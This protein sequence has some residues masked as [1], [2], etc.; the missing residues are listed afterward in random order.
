MT[1]RDT[2]GRDQPLSDTE[3]DGGTGA[4]KVPGTPE[5]TVTP[6][7]TATTE[8]TGTTVDTELTPAAERPA[9]EGQVLLVRRRRVPALGFWVTLALALSFVGGVVLA[10]TTSVRDVSG[11]LYFG[12]TAI[13]LV[14]LPLAAVAAVVDSLTHRRGRSGRRS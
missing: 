9:D 8:V 6:E 2:D 1:P 11:L 5:T 10:W 7:T 12:V 4:M 13:F 14:G 3:A